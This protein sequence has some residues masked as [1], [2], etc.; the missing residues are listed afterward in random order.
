M[1]AAQGNMKEEQN[2]IQL[3]FIS[4]PIII[5]YMINY[6][7]PTGQKWIKGVFEIVPLPQNQKGRCGAQNTFY[8]ASW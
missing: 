4:L 1:K 3:L 5:I 6:F 8:I 7:I 2:L